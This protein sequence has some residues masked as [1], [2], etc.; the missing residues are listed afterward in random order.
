MY[1]KFTEL[2]FRRHSYARSNFHLKMKLTA[3]LI[4]IAVIQL[5]AETFAQKI[6]VNVNNARL[7]EVIA[8]LKKQTDYDFLYNNEV[9]KHVKPVTLNVKDANL[10]EV[11]DKCFNDQPV[12]YSISNK[13]VLIMARPARQP[14]IN[15]YR[16]QKLRITGTVTDETNGEPLIGAS[17]VVEGTAIGASTGEKGFFAL[18][19]PGPGTVL[20]VSYVGFQTKKVPVGSQT[21]LQVKLAHSDARLGELVV[22]GYGTRTKGAITGAITTVKS[23]VFESRPLNNSYD[24]LQG[25]IP[26]L[27]ITKAS[28]QPGSTTYGFQVRGYSSVNGNAPLV[29]IDGIP[30]DINTINT[31]DIAEVTVLKDAAAAIYG[32]RAANGVII[33][34]TKRG[35]KGP[36]SVTYTTN[37]GYKTPTY[38]RKMQNTMEFARFMDEGLRNAG[39]NGFSQEVFDKIATNAPPDPTGW[40]YGVTNYPGFYGY[41]DW[42][43][44]I[45]KNTTQQLHNINVSGGGENNNYLLSAGYNRDNGIVRF[46]ENNSNGY[47]IRLNYDFRFNNHFAVETR[48][49]FDNRAVVT[50]TLLGSALTNV[51][52]QFPYQ[53][54]YNKAGQ[55]YGY[56]GYESPAQYLAEGGTQL[57][58]LSRFGANIKIDYTI[59]PGLKLTGQSAVR[60]DY[61]NGSTTNRTITRYNW[62]GG[63]Q[64]VRNTP[65]SANYSNDKVLN[66]LYQA[67]LDY[68]KKL[69]QDHSINLTGGASLEQTRRE[70]QSTNGYNFISNDIFTLNLA[71][72]TKAAYA[73]F[74][75]YLN[76]EALVSYF[77]RLSYTF[78]EKLIVDFTARADGSSKFSP[79][80]RWS[81]VFPS[82][83]V[84][85]NLSEE[86]FIKKMNVLD[87]LKLRLSYGKMGNQDLEGLGLYD[88][89]PLISING[90]YPIG[91]PNAG[92]TG[93]NAN[94]ASSTRT[95]ETIETRNIGIDLAT[96][97][98][99]LS[100][101]FDYYNKINND[102][103]VNV[104]VPAS[105]GATPPST[106]QG[107][108]NTKGFEMML[109]WKDQVHDFRYGVS[110]QLSDSK[111]KLVELKNTDNYGEGLNKYRQGYPIYSY[112]GYVYDGIIKT[113]QQLD[114]YK[115][116]EGIPSR[117]SLGDVM[118]KDVDGD[119]K[120]TAF[121]DKTKGLSGDMIYLGN[122]TPRYTYSAN[123]SAGYKNF[124]VQVFL[125]GVGK[126][127]VIYE[128]AISQP[129]TFF[130][131]SLQ[132]FYGKTWSPERPDAKYP[133]YLPGNLGYDDVKN[134]NYR[135]SALTLR[136]VAYLRFKVIT[137]GYTIPEHIAKRARIK[138]ARV[139]FSGQDLF[140]FSKGTLG[141][142]FDPEDGYRNE[143]TYPFNKVYSLGLNVKF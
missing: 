73:N 126:R 20:V 140:T 100:F 3:I 121:G 104:A 106:N 11:L 8:Q 26:G 137:L 120:L 34:S 28:G 129:N 41:T 62:D 111:N 18:D 52:R 68:N 10:K 92:L 43:K 44:V 94:P 102:M 33:V 135:A 60:L 119:G 71:D 51:T 13:T 7:T 21:T 6:S 12:S 98:S 9:I 124:D 133:R 19:A 16:K 61:A 77:G 132:Y 90:N 59:I 105:F 130:W 78:R 24:A 108:L 96:L 114:N 125:Q 86:R 99:R 127:D 23:D 123:L 45:Y 25:T 56:Q 87:L 58:N 81:A 47:N 134:Y 138:S 49:Y 83:A 37:I 112:F 14:E 54:V 17:V 103:L 27:T 89:I 88:Y 5:K 107:K 63:I 4:V 69:S 32:A 2:L 75:G 42:N 22:V 80:K 48:S 131:P 91:S 31:N 109:T 136:N 84:A 15:D 141:G 35:K 116:L 39:I 40:N 29:L 97:Q 115:K 139:Y 93:A 95:W 122:L 30:G 66:K 117:I 50:P 64:D 118:Y 67:Y 143:G 101:S 79:D 142:N 70:G 72:R 82:A 128:G 46:G 1:K 110:L 36:P 76:N 65:N 85:Y 38:L 55:F 57:S 113:Q 74:T 53:P